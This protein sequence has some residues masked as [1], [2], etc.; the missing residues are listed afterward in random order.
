MQT[1]GKVGCISCW[2]KVTISSLH[3]LHI[4]LIGLKNQKVRQNRSILEFFCMIR[5]FT[6]EDL[7]Y[8][9]LTIGIQLLRLPFP[10]FRRLLLH[11]LHFVVV[12]FFH[13]YG[14]HLDG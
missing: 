5:N 10:N 8:I 2:T 14:V 7:R 9:K 3:C 6:V 11:Y 4:A 1:K 13:I 12:L